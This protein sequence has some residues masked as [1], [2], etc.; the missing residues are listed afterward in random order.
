VL[1]ARQ[2]GVVRLRQTSIRRYDLHTHGRSGHN[3]DRGNYVGAGVTSSFNTFLLAPT[4]HRRSACRHGGTAKP[5][6][7]LWTIHKTNGGPG[8][9]PIANGIL[10]VNRSNGATPHLRVLHLPGRASGRLFHYRLF[11]GAASP[12]GDPNN[13]FLRS[14]FLGRRPR[15]LPFQPSYLPGFAHDGVERASADPAPAGKLPPGLYPIIGPEI[16]TYRVAAD[17]AARWFGRSSHAA[18]TH[19]RYLTLRTLGR[20]PGLGLSDWDRF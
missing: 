17:R 5:A 15:R 10:V 1:G 20:R 18:R 3:A 7:R 19:R 9:R 8:D 4:I 13:C 16:A 12:G 6:R 2:A 14:T 11:P